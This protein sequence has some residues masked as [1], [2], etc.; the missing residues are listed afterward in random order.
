MFPFVGD[1]N[2]IAFFKLHAPLYLDVVDSGGCTTALDGF[3]T[4]VLVAYKFKFPDNAPS[5]ASEGL[6][7]A[8]SCI[9]I[10]GFTLM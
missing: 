10:E 9:Y 7:K 3:L 5:L 2:Q 8:V 6:W 4:Q 1:D